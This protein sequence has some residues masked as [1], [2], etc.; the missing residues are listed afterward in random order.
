M[1]ETILIH[2]GMKPYCDLTKYSYRLEGD[3]MSVVC[4]SLAR[5]NWL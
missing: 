1:F 2:D 3:A 5:Y 4:R